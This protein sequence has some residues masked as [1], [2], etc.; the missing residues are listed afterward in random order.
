MLRDPNLQMRY[1]SLKNYSNACEAN[2]EEVKHIENINNI[3]HYK[4]SGSKFT[5][6]W[7]FPILLHFPLNIL[8]LE[9]SNNV[10]S[11]KILLSSTKCSW[12]TL[13]WCIIKIAY[14]YQNKVQ[15]SWP[16]TKQ[17]WSWQELGICICTKMKVLGLLPK[18]VSLGLCRNW[19]Y[20]LQ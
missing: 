12:F 8:N 3:E 14:R 17:M 7:I 18:G 20:F 19:W 1:N 9:P 11:F 13:W 5:R 16:I 2:L 4:H 15:L 6:L 10:T